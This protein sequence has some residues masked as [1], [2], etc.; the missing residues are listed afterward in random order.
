MSVCAASGFAHVRR[1]LGVAA[2]M[3]N[4]MSSDK[5]DPDPVRRPRVIKRPFVPPGRLAELKALIYELYL[6]AGTPTLDE[7]TTRTDRSG[8][9]LAGNPRRD[10]INRIIGDPGMPASQA[11]VVAVVTVLARE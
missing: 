8:S 1:H 10:T 5:E 4:A 6:A 7:I 3:A 11:D 2:I 9:D